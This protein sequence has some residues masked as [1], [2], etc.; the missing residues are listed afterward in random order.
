M[1]GKGAGKGYR[2]PSKG[3]K[4]DALN[5]QV[6]QMSMAMNVS[7][8]M[9]SRQGQN[10]Q[11]LQQD[12]QEIANRQ[13][14]IQYRI[15]ALAELC[16]VDET[17]LNELVT[18]KQ[19]IDYNELSDKEDQEKGY[20]LADEVTENSVVII[21]SKTPELEEDKGILRSK[22]TWSEIGFP[23]LK[24]GLL[25]KKVGDKTEA[26]VNG[27]LHVC[28]VVGIRNMPQVEENIEEVN[29]TTNV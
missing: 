25:G 12:L 11:Q 4:F 29:G 18:E 15:L 8:M 10:Q 6:N 22:L 5:K 3:E 7:Q 1:S 24:E 20:T 9:I 2:A 23:D 21:T 28:E 16:S 27:T 26:M 13:R 19:L 17:K 14:E